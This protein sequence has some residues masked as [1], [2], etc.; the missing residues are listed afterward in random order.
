MLP[1]TPGVAPIA[2]HNPRLDGVGIEV[3]S[4]ES[5]R[6]LAPHTLLHPQRPGFHLLLL[7]H[8]GVGEHTVDFQH[9][10]L[11]PGSLVYVRPGQV[12][13]WHMHAGL[14]GDCMLIKPEALSP[15]IGR[16]GLDMQLLGMHSWQT[17]LVPDAALREHV[18]CDMAR[19]RA[20]IAH[21]D[22]SQTQIS[23][24]WHTLLAT[25]LRVA[26]AMR[27]KRGAANHA[28]AAIFSLFE[29]L[30]AEEGHRR[31][32]VSAYAKKLGYSESTLNRAC[33]AM[34]EKTAKQLLDERTALE[35]K[36]LLVHSPASIHEIG[37]HLGFSESTNF[38]KF[39]ARLA[40]T[41]PQRFRDQYTRHGLAS[42]PP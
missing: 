16:P 27:A 19:L 22:G 31:Q 15:A 35:A 5:I 18:Q 28:A 39:F 17:L 37:H 2:F 23:I 8:A 12:Q 33:M 41:T 24:I 36:R 21:F 11:A 14:E 7:M 4:L 38:V 20:D 40:H 13:Q 9:Y 26:Q 3:L 30:L 42:L 6:T 25:L 34:A 29:Q 1:K 10:P 32:A